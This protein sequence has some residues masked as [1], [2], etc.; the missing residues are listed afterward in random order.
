MRVCR[1]CGDIVAKIE[2]GMLI[3]FQMIAGNVYDV[4]FHVA[5][6]IHHT[7]RYEVF[8]EEV[9]GHHEPCFVTR[10]TQIMRPRVQTEVYDSRV[11][12]PTHCLR[13]FRIG[14][15][16]HYHLPACPAK[17]SVINRRVS[18]LLVSSS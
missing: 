14:D 3:E 4:N 1:T 13:M 7:A 9:I 18:T 15:I 6:C 11:W 12:V 5:F 8:D 2:I 16:E 10:Q 17:L